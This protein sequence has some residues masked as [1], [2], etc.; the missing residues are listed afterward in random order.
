VS[1]VNAVHPPQPVELV[2]VTR[3]N[4]LAAIALRVRAD[5]E[6]FV[7]SVAVSLAKVAIQPDGPEEQF[8][9]Y[10]VV[11][12]DEMVGFG[13]LVGQFGRAQTLWIGG[14]LIDARYQGRGFGRAALDGLIRLAADE[15]SC[16][17]VGLTVAPANGHAR[18]LY[19]AMG[20]V[21]TGAVWDDELVHRLGLEPR[22][23]R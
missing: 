15:P 8:R 6:S 19:R 3:D 23:P 2:P 9:S 11:S 12:E 5:Q 20:F 1:A 17:A 14:L 4:W 7:P 21:E 18:R 22:G 10:G 13:Q 16:V